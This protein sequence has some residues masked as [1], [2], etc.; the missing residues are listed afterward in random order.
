MELNISAEKIK[1]I[2]IVISIGKLLITIFI[3]NF[4]KNK[5]YRINKIK[6]E[7]SL[8]RE[9]H[10]DFF[11][12]KKKIAHI[13]FQKF[14]GYKIPYDEFKFIFLDD[15]FSSYCRDLKNGRSYLKFDGE[16]YYMTKWNLFLL[17]CSFVFYF[18]TTGPLLIYILFLK[19][20]H[21]YFYTLKLN[22][23]SDYFLRIDIFI[24]A[25][26][27][28]LTIFSSLKLSWISSAYRI[29]KLNKKK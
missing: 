14:I 15:N 28:V 2:K 8:L 16:K 23:N 19:E 17:G 29:H 11:S 1:V 13:G 9:I 25:I 18:I 22:L 5:L 20:I 24:I 7:Y 4:T 21:N 10:D 3:T 6:K 26:L 27:F 12:R